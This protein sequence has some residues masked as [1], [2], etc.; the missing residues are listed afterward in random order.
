MENT[1][2][3]FKDFH[4]IYDF[5]GERNFTAL[6]PKEESREQVQFHKAFNIHIYL[7]FLFVAHFNP[8][9]IFFKMHA[10]FH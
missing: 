2:T 8:Y 4:F 7:L 9:M 1:N 5:K 6:D 10:P 3:E